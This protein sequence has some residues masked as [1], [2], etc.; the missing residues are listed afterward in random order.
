VHG[1]RS[2]WTTPDAPGFSVCEACYED[3][4]ATGPFARRFRLETLPLGYVCDTSFT[5]I[6]R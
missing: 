2:W 1:S 3:D 6:R 5:S 4:I